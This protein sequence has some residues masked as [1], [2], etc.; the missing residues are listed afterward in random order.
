M[1]LQQVLVDL[2]YFYLQL[3]KENKYAEQQVKRKRKGYKK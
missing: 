2:D 1:T 3:D